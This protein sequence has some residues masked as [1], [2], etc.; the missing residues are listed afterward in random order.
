ML[1]RLAATMS[2]YPAALAWVGGALVV[3]AVLVFGTVFIPRGGHPLGEGGPTNAALFP[4]F[5]ADVVPGKYIVSIEASGKKELL[6]ETASR[7]FARAKGLRNQIAGLVEEGHG[8][9]GFKYDSALLGFSARMSPWLAKAIQAKAIKLKAINAGL[10]V[11]V[12]P[13]HRVRLAATQTNPPYGLDRISERAGCL[14]GQFTYSLTGN[15]VHVY[16]IDTGIL[17]GHPEF[18]TPSGQ[19]R[20]SVVYNA[21]ADGVLDDHGHGTHVAG[22]IGGKTYGV[23]KEVTLHS[24][25]VFKLGKESDTAVVIEGIDRA[26]KDA[27]DNRYVPYAIVNMSLASPKDKPLNNSIKGSIAKGLTFVVAAGNRDAQHPDRNACNASPASAPDAITVGALNPG[28]D[29]IADFSFVGSCVDTFAPGVYILSARNDLSGQPVFMHG[30]S[31]A[32]AHVS[33]IA[34]LYLGSRIGQTPKS[35]PSAVWQA[36][37]NAAS[38]HPG[39]V[40]WAGIKGSLWNSPNQLSH[41]GSASADGKV[42]GESCTF[43]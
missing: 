23:A 16:V 40:E 39:T 27:V 7:E 42:D 30:A 14:N 31:M 21:F 11:R 36:V 25:R 3:L 24:V 6:P 4:P 37:F 1:E 8:E 9:V 18:A 17:I 2:R 13:V 29:T 22:T 15:G 10:R 35:T 43:P 34:A 20:A 38:K 33:G 12:D 41:W 5:D 32:A 28:N 26:T 19:S